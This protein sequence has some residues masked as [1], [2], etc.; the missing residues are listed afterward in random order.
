MKSQ[1]GMGCSMAPGRRGDETLLRSV[2]PAIQ[3]V[4]K[5][6]WQPVTHAWAKSL[7]VERSGSRRGRLYFGV[8]NTGDRSVRAEPSID[9]KALGLDSS[10]KLPRVSTVYGTDAGGFTTGKGIRRSTVTVPSGRTCSLAVR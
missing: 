2:M 9:V 7:H 5:A 4:A 8:R 3:R 10:R 1:Q 6:G